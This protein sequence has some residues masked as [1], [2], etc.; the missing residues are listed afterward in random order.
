M[1]LDVCSTLAAFLEPDRDP[2]E[3]APERV[4]LDTEPLTWELGKLYVYPVQVD[5]VPFETATSR[6]Q[7][8]DII[9]A[10]IVS[11]EGE[12]ALLRRSPSLAEALD[13][14]RGQ[15]L[16]AVRTHQNH[17]V[18]GMIRG[19]SDGSSPRMLDKRSAAIRISGWRI[20][21]G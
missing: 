9:A 21:G 16:A 7:E 20:I 12:E 4:V 1:I 5:E 15:Y 6:R 19:R 11:N 13:E 10:R 2:P 8:F 17:P 18:W 3:A 14:L